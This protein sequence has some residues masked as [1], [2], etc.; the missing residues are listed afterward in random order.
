M[1]AK[2]EW[3]ESSSAKNE[4]GWN[5]R[6]HKTIVTRVTGRSQQIVN[7]ETVIVFKSE[8]FSEMASQHAGSQPSPL[9]PCFSKPLPSW[10]RLLWMRKECPRLNYNIKLNSTS[11][12]LRGVLRMH[13]CAAQTC[14]VCLHF[15]SYQKV[16]AK[17]SE[18]KVY[19]GEQWDIT[20]NFLL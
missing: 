11:Y 3:R 15:S 9:L 2:T 6:K 17:L 5:G 12:Q 16:W 4:P 8:D 20:S 14:P 19:L 7:L 1:S 13:L 18:S 10:C